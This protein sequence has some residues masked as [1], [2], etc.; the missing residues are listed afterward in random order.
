MTNFNY[1]IPI[2]YTIVY[3]A[4]SVSLI[5]IIVANE[6]VRAFTLLGAFAV[7]R[8]RTPIKDARDGAFIFVALAAGMGAGV[9]M[10]VETVLG[11]ALIGIFMLLMHRYKFGLLATRETLVKF[12]VSSGE[13]DRADGHKEV[14][15]RY[16]T[17]FN[18]VNVRSLHEG[19]E[20]EL[21]F[22]VRP[23]R[24]AD[25]VAFSRDLGRVPRLQQVSMIVCE[26]DEVPDN[27][28]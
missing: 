27:V 8:F 17:D 25:M 3:V 14:F 22:Y 12:V 20:T 11:T 16:L 7:I 15:E 4:L 5:M 26:D 13:D 6:L 24:E 21:T 10:Y 18:L 9:G 28:F 23:K 1:S 19:R 2:M